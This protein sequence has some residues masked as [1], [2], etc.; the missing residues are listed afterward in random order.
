MDLFV[1]GISHKTAPVALRERLAVIPAEVEG[2]LRQLADLPAMREAALVSTCNR[3]E[4]YGVSPSCDQALSEIRGLLAAQLAGAG[5]SVSATEEAR[6][7]G[8]H[9]YARLGREAVHHLFRVAASLDS[10]VV[11]EPQILGQIKEAFE[12]ALRAGTAGPVLG[13]LFP[14]AFRVARKVRRDTAIAEQPVSVSSVAVDL[15]RQVWGGFDQRR[16]LLVGAGKMADLAARALRS[17][18][19][20]IAVTNRTRGRADE[21]AAR[22]GGSVEPFERLDMALVMADI[23]ISSTGAREPVLR[24]PLLAEVQRARRGRPLVLIDIAVPRNV[25]PEVAEL[26]G[27]FLF[28]IDDLQKELAANLQDRRQEAARAEALV[29]GELGRFLATHRGRAAGPT[30]AA[31]RARFQSVAR[32]EAERTLAG[33]SGAD[34]RARRAVLALADAIVGKLLHAPSLALKRE[35]AEGGERVDL[36]TAAHRLFE[37]PPLEAL[38]APLGETGTISVDEGGIAE[39]VVQVPSAGAAPAQAAEAGPPKEAAGS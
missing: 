26:D 3:V 5:A 39:A 30:I 13:F 11:G 2:V 33:L 24:R 29:E 17:H 6:A 31:L 10:L 27:V 4:I 38:E 15:A 16:V 28:D 9:L 7:M 35:A 37:L 32:N 1:I 12:I 18:G 14:R 19:A 8:R 23:V 20:E 25:E 34:E 22:L 36:F 21:L